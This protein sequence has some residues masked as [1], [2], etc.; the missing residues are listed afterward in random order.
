M[1][2]CA[3]WENHIY[4]YGGSPDASPIE[5]LRSNIKKRVAHSQYKHLNNIGLIER[6]SLQNELVT[7]YLYL[8]Q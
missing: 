1:F 7:H 3:H 8:T 6:I 5:N 4:F 2:S